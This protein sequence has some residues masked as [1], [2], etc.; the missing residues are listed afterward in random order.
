M[1][2]ERATGVDPVYGMTVDIQHATS[3]G[4]ATE[5][6]GATYHFCGKG[7]KLELDDDPGTYLDPSHTPSM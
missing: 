4:L 3:V 2:E 1:T 7:C 6:E 5:H